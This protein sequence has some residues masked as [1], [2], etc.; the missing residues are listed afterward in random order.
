[1]D[2]HKAGYVRFGGVSDDDRYI[3]EMLRKTCSDGSTTVSDINS[4]RHLLNG[5]GAHYIHHIS[6]EEDSAN[7][8]SINGGSTDNEFSI[9]RDELYEFHRASGA[10]NPGFIW[11]VKTNRGAFPFMKMWERDH[12]LSTE[13]PF[14]ILMSSGDLAAKFRGLVQKMVDPKIYF[15]LDEPTR[16][17]INYFHNS[18]LFNRV[19]VR[20]WISGISKVVPQ[21]DMWLPMVPGLTHIE[22][23]IMLFKMFIWKYLVHPEKTSDLL[24]SE[25]LFEDEEK[26]KKAKEEFKEMM[27]Q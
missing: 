10:I 3:P 16:Q 5:V 24:V 26:M 22:T 19:K 8:D 15:R 12:Y 2:Y 7:G 17:Q 20:Y 25:G 21:M 6:K 13:V 4:M 27:N 1:M 14:K 11:Y 23:T 9:S 18:N